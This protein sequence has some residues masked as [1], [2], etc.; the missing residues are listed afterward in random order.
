[1]VRGDEQRGRI[2]ERVVVEQQPRV[3]VAVRRDHRRLA[4]RLVEPAGDRTRVGVGRQEA[5]WMQSQRWDRDGHGVILPWTAGRT[6]E[7]G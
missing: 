7:G 5:I 2:R 1:V 6:L 4:Y 3:D